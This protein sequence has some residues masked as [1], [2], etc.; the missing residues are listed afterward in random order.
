[1]I[2]LILRYGLILLAVTVSTSGLLALVNQITGPKIAKGKQDAL[3]AS[4]ILVLPGASNSNLHKFRRDG[5]SYYSGYSSQ[6]STQLIG[7]A[8][9]VQSK[10]YSSVIWT[11]VGL[12]TSGKI[13]K[14]KVLDQQETP[15]LGTKCTEIRPGENEPWWQ[16]QFQNRM[17][18][19]VAVDKDH[20]DIQSITGATITSRAITDAIADSSEFFLEQISGWEQ[21][22]VL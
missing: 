7:Y 5:F 6:D 20:G 12:D 22:H 8:F 4:L 21:D 10:G 1:M 9:T 15:G 3:N 2:K 14:I 17:A 13:I 11:L 16:F 19:N 18:A